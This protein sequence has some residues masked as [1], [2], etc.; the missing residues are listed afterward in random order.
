MYSKYLLILDK[1]FKVIKKYKHKIKDF[2]CKIK[3]FIIGAF[4]SNQPV[5]LNYLLIQGSC[6]YIYKHYRGIISL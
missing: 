1:Q 4:Y 6:I 3:I 2:F 5:S